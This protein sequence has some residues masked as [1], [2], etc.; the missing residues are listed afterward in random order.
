[1]DGSLELQLIVPD[2]FD[3][4]MAIA[5]SLP[6]WFN[7]LDNEQVAV[8]LRHQRN[9]VAEVDGDIA[10]SVAWLS[11]AGLR[12]IGWNVVGSGCHQTASERV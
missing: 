2:D 10:A 12:G 4:V 9:A 6:E 5:L 7:D 1:M 8:D 3:A 11:R